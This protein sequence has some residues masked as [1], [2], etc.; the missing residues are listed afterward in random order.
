MRVRTSKHLAVR[1]GRIEGQKTGGLDH[2]EKGDRKKVAN[3]LS[4]SIL[5]VSRLVARFYGRERVSKLDNYHRINTLAALIRKNKR[6]MRISVSNDLPVWDGRLEGLHQRERAHNSL[7]WNILQVSRL[8]A[9]FYGREAV[10]KFDKYHIINTLRTLIRKNK[11][12]CT[13]SKIVPGFSYFPGSSTSRC[14]FAAST[15]FG[16]NGRTNV[17]PS[18]HA[19]H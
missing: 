18:Y 10:S 9:I 17:V 8:L 16:L 15:A 3:S 1:P 7:S 4:C 14:A 5:Q 19:F 6:C 12:R 11:R 13:P 2:C